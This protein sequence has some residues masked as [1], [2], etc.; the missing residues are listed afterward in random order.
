MRKFLWILIVGVLFYTSGLSIASASANNPQE[1]TYGDTIKL[2]FDEREWKLGADNAKTNIF[3]EYVTDGQTVN[4]WKEM[5][6]LQMFKGM[7]KK[8]TTEKYIKGYISM[9]Y[10]ACGDKLV[11]SLIR[12][13]PSDYMIE[14][15]VNGHPKIDNQYE[16]DRV[17][18]G[19]EALI[20]IHYAIKTARISPDNRAKWIQIVDKA[21]LE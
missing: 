3:Y 8:I 5:V 10:N 13:D 7:Q 11:V 16:I 4:D 20:V 2:Y 18:V 17:I 1:I 6:T 12:N 19:K 9:L 21:T 15:K 14:W